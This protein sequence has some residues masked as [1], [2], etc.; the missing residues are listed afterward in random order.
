MESRSDI[1]WAAPPT[2]QDGPQATAVITLDANGTGKLQEELRTL[3][4]E[5]TVWQARLMPADGNSAP[6]L[7]RIRQPYAEYS[8]LYT[9]LSQKLKQSQEKLATVYSQ[10]EWMYKNAPTDSQYP[11]LHRAYYDCVQLH[12][13][14]FEIFG[15]LSRPE[16][17]RNQTASFRNSKLVARLQTIV[18]GSPAEP[19]FSVRK[20]DKIIFVGNYNE[21]EL[22]LIL[23]GESAFYVVTVCPAPA[24]GPA[25]CQE[26]TR[27]S[28]FSAEGIENNSAHQHLE[29]ILTEHLHRISLADEERKSLLN[30]LSIARSYATPQE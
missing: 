5:L 27:S 4:Q 24:T 3:L 23:E 1:T 22:Y 9:E 10:L 13:Q 8:A 2:G 26:L 12:T 11:A 17:T 6:G 20:A 25:D 30:L 16:Q 18:P 19:E 28:V 21:A 29:R 15:K 14:L 7:D